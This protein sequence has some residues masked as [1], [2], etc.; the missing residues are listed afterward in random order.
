M[1]NKLYLDYAPEYSEA[2]KKNIYNALFE[3][4][5]LQ[6]MLPD[7]KGKTVL[8]LG[9]GSGEHSRH[10]QSKGA[11]V[12][13]IDISQTM[14]DLIQKQNQ[15][16]LKAYTQD[17]SKGLPNELDESFDVVISGLTIHYIKD[18]TPLFS[19]INRVLKKEGKFIFSTHHPVFDLK[20]SISGNYFE[21]ELI[22]QEWD[23]ID[24]PVE[25]S[26]YRRPLTELF[27]AITRAD[28]CV[29]GLNEGM[30]QNEIQKLNP[31]TYKRLTT[32]PCF[33]FIE[34]TKK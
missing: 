7:L 27:S 8:D 15:G 33:L 19:D 22:T 12:T 24:E 32:K 18:L 9:C 5:S 16:S 14:I 21:Q 34:C 1:N 29:T 2:I 13:A 30:V 4:P 23:V 20:S 26:F 31:A 11:N 25:V 17:I 28:F 10:L 3:R 6:A